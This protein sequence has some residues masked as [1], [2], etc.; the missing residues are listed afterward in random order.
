[1]IPMI[2]ILI[3][4]EAVTFFNLQNIHTILVNCHCAE[5][6]RHSLTTLLGTP[7]QLHCMHCMSGYY[8][9]VAR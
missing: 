2:V 1:M 4:D 9:Q 6:R 7:V 3:Y 8:T 5:K